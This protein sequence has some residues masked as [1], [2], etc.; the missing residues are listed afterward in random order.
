MISL[1]L[2]CF[3]NQPDKQISDWKRRVESNPTELDE[4]LNVYMEKKKE[5]EK[6]ISVLKDTVQSSAEKQKSEIEGR[7]SQI[8][9][10][11]KELEETRSREQ[12]ARQET[13]SMQEQLT[14]LSEAYGQLE[15][16]FR[17]QTAFSASA[18]PAVTAAGQVQPQGETSEQAPPVAPGGSTEI[19]MLRA[20]NA[21]LR[22]DAKSADEWMTMAVERMNEMGAQNGSLQQEVASLKSQLEAIQV[23]DSTNVGEAQKALETERSL[24]LNLEAQLTEAMQRLEFLQAGE[25][26]NQQ[27]SEANG[28]QLA[29]L[30]QSLDDERTRR[31]VLETKMERFR[32][33]AKAAMASA[34]EASAKR[35]EME[36]LVESLRSELDSLRSGQEQAGEANT[37]TVESGDLSKE[38]SEARA[39]M[40]TRQTHDQE[41]I[42]KL[43]ARIRELEARLD[44]G[45]GGY[46]VEDIHKRDEEIAQLEEANAAAQDWMAKAVEHHQMLANQVA[47]LTHEKTIMGGELKELK[48]R[49]S[50]TD[51]S[52]ASNRIATMEAQLDEKTRELEGIQRAIEERDR[53]I[54]SLKLDAIE[55]D[56]ARLQELESQVCTL[57]KQLVDQEHDASSV[58]AQWQESYAAMEKNRNDLAEELDHLREQKCDSSDGANDPPTNSVTG[59][60]EREMQ[61]LK[62]QASKASEIASEWEGRCTALLNEKKELEESFLSVQREKTELE[63]RLLEEKA[64]ESGVD[65]NHAQQ[66]A[67]LQAQVESLQ[68][69]LMEQ[70]KQAN[71]VI[72]QWQESYTALEAAKGSAEVHEEKESTTTPYSES[73]STGS[74]PESAQ[75]ARIAELEKE[76]QVQEQQANEVISQWQESYTAMEANK[77]ALERQLEQMRED[78]PTESQKEDETS[79]AVAMLES[80]IEKLK[81]ELKEQEEEANKVISQWQ[82]SFMSME[83]RNKELESEL[84]RNR[85][86][87]DGLRTE[88]PEEPEKYKDQIADLQARVEGLERELA[89]QEAQANAVISQ[90][91]ES[92]TAMESNKF[93]L[94]TELAALR[95]NLSPSDPNEETDVNT[96]RVAGLE[97]E[98]TGLKL[99]LEEQGKRSSEELDLAKSQISDLEAEI[100][101]LRARLATENSSADPS[102]ASETSKSELETRIKELENELSKQEAD[103]LEAI[104][105]WQESYQTLE[106][107]LEKMRNIETSTRESGDP[108]GAGD[109][110]VTVKR[111]EAELADQA[112]EANDVIARWQESYSALESEKLELASKLED[113]QMHLSKSSGALSETAESAING[114]EA[115]V[116]AEE[117]GTKADDGSVA[118]EEDDQTSTNQIDLEQENERLKA[119]VLELSEKAKG[120]SAL[121]ETVKSLLQQLE[122][123]EGQSDKA[124]QELKESLASSEA[125]KS[126][127]ENDVEDLRQ[128]ISQTEKLSENSSREY[129]SRIAEFE[130]KVNDLKNQIASQENEAEEAIAQW[131]SSYG[132]IQ[133]QKDE[134]EKE[135][136]MLRGISASATTQAVAPADADSEEKIQLLQDQLEQQEK[137]ANEAIAEWQRSY[138]SAEAVKAELELEL[139]TLR[140]QFSSD[141]PGEAGCQDGDSDVNTD[142][143][144][145]GAANSTKDND[146]TGSDPDHMPHSDVSGDNIPSPDDLDLKIVTLEE[147]VKHLEGQLEIQGKEADDVV[148]QWQQSYADMESQ[149]NE[150]ASQLAE[151]RGDSA[152]GKDASD[153]AAQIEDLQAKVTMLEE[154][155]IEQENQAT[156]A[157]AQWEES[158]NMLKAKSS[159]AESNNNL[160]LLE[161][162]IS[163]L[164]ND[165][166]RQ[167]AEARNVISQ[168]EARYSES[169]ADVE[170]LRSKLAEMEGQSE[171]ASKTL[172]TSVDEWRSKVDELMIRSENQI[173]KI[174]QLS[175]ELEQATELRKGLEEEHE[176]LKIRCSELQGELDHFREQTQLHKETVK[177]QEQEI[178]D[179]RQQVE[180]RGAPGEAAERLHAA[181]QELARLQESLKSNDEENTEL[182]EALNASVT[183]LG[184]SQQDIDSLR[185]ELRQMTSRNES[186]EA[187]LEEK[188]QVMLNE[189]SEA[190]AVINEWE[191][192]F[193]DLEGR[194]AELESEVGALKKERDDLTVSLRVS[195]WKFVSEK[196]ANQTLLAKFETP[197]SQLLQAGDSLL[198]EKGSLMEE[199]GSLRAQLSASRDDLAEAKEK[200]ISL[201]KEHDSFS[202]ESQE[203]IAQWK[204]KCRFPVLICF[205]LTQSS[206]QNLLRY[207]RE[208]V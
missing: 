190:E 12:E 99:E 139:E 85:E 14:S 29:A 89:D 120:I 197:E 80:E 101:S 70:E 96:D 163:E 82:E 35:K 176:N 23:S 168:W 132:V 39:E 64:A 173:E 130:A 148:S 125:R 110:E 149:R 78:T 28:T 155:L 152:L 77:I 124:I 74:R 98:L 79:S 143:R 63:R 187:A 47:D 169:E 53:L 10:I 186:L 189:R 91:Q 202:L 32:A 177:S 195:E 102:S 92:Y 200:I 65:E 11:K 37:G 24:R 160:E 17:Q 44:G 111:L 123:Q 87:S 133:S 97:N 140:A 117:L 20:D 159:E 182:S 103:S 208:S 109:L 8:D 122:E 56:P 167:S 203:I 21:R 158:Y 153:L 60:T 161:K 43:E 26:S 2:S 126:E 76:L 204:G 66:V 154:Q 38:L 68:K 116:A 45:L 171:Q 62:M 194:V 50:S 48:T 41:V 36:D 15:A 205:S 27:A 42:Y 164:E 6:E 106:S 162:K 46:T 174:T 135:I 5:L 119:M 156:E 138:E 57:K 9:A 61:D 193:H 151:I 52:D 88:E 137:E 58:I 4:M 25:V 73:E 142:G 7:E 114:P 185:D 13:E 40:D 170:Q 147:Q 30:S 175:E 192:C 69:Q 188:E 157:I 184:A 144:T 108:D 105:K 95:Q 115:A 207:H 181:E 93:E 19:A 90:W 22:N 206:H 55:V 3:A 104:S 51:L 191:S 121:Q 54:E 34:D 166:E 199:V 129:D 196:T 107:E 81:E 1:P 33:D 131:E 94:E 127:L 141:S 179:L 67:D 72:Q 113:L 178:I 128:Q 134:L 118:V 150:L 49:L 84:E 183:S 172:D 180:E 146:P 86:V 100:A 201:E 71:E 31:E 59:D 18:P 112:Q 75:Q 198:K 145:S 136:E 165:L 83:T 16:D